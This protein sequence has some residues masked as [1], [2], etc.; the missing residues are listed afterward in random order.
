MS[1][2]NCMK[3]HLIIRAIFFIGLIALQTSVTA[4]Q[5]EGKATEWPIDTRCGTPV[6]VGYVVNGNT[7]YYL[8]LE[9]LH[10]KKNTLEKLFKCF[11][12]RHSRELYFHI[13]AF[14]DQV[15]LR[16]AIRNARTALPDVNPPD[17]SSTEDC[18]DL[19][20]AFRP[21]PTGYFRAF[22]W[23]GRKEYFEYSPDI[24][25]GKLIRVNIRKKVSWRRSE[26]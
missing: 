14:S 23:R 19:E 1:I 15:N 4:G 17:D 18:R 26:S 16:I 7:T 12:A 5:E 6:K 11:S 8:L 2:E 25:S 24:V 21:C 20:K 13:V 9:S 22:Y 3:L 10:F